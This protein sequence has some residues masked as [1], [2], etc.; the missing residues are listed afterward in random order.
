[1]GHQRAR[2]LTHAKD[3]IENVLI[4][5]RLVA[6]ER[7]QLS[8][9]HTLITHPLD[10]AGDVQQRGNDPQIARDRRLTREHRQDALLDVQ[11]SPF[12]PVTVGDR[13]PGQLDVLVDRGFHRAIECLDHDLEPIESLALELHQI[14][15]ELVATLL[16]PRTVLPRDVVPP[17]RLLTL[18][19]RNRP[20]ARA[21][22]PHAEFA[23]PQRKG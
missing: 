7:H 4:H 22:R 2:Y 1:L 14:F 12:D 19:E 16:D 5:W 15:T 3:R 6:R 20:L 13:H 21:D 11:R 8:D 23:R 17:R 9:V 10:A 18:S